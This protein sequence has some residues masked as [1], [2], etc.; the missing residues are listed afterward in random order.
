MS[1]VNRLFVYGTLRLEHPNSRMF[2]LTPDNLVKQGV[3]L[4]GHKIFDVSWFPGVQ[5]GD[6]TV[7]GDVFEVTTDSQWASLDAYEG[8]PTLYKREVV[9]VMGEPCYTYIYQGDPGQLIEDGDWLQ[10]SKREVG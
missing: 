10:W 1:T 9:E 5:P 2:G 6:G 8:T 7:M 3:E 4:Y